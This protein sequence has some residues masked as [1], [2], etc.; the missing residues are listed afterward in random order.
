MRMET[1]SRLWLLFIVVFALAT[2]WA[3][4]VEAQEYEE[5]K[6]GPSLQQMCEENAS[7]MVN[8]AYRNEE[9]PASGEYAVDIHNHVYEMLWHRCMAIM[10]V[11]KQQGVKIDAEDESI[12]P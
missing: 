9:L 8:I 10:Y 4:K 3:W 7:T 2:A 1:Q 11:A 12:D 6:G 5:Y